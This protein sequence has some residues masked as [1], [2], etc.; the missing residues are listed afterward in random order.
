MAALLCG[1]AIR[2]KASTSLQVSDV[3]G[4]HWSTGNVFS[5]LKVLRIVH[6]NIS[7]CSSCTL[8]DNSKTV[9]WSSMSFRLASVSNV[10][11]F[12]FHNSSISVFFVDELHE[13]SFAVVRVLLVEFGVLLL[14]E[15]LGVRVDQFSRNILR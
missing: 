12:N 10:E 6:T 1:A 15:L 8:P 5:V 11:L 9:F 3:L 2:K 4:K 7:F 13:N 14:R